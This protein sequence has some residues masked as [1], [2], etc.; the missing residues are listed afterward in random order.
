MGD[1]LSVEW[2]EVWCVPHW[3]A[4]ESHSRC[5]LMVATLT[6]AMRLWQNLAAEDPE[7]QYTQA[8]FHQ[9]LAELGPLCCAFGMSYTARVLV[10]SQNYAPQLI[11]PPER[12]QAEVR[13]QL[14]QAAAQSVNIPRLVEELGPAHVLS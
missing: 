4:A 12:Y 14:E 9:R 11:P 5:N 8:E 13:V 2:S 10:L 7:R 3:G 6:L 1:M